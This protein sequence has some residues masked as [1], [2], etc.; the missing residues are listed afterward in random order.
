MPS[1]DPVAASVASVA[2]PVPLAAEAFYGPL[3][4]FVTI[5]D[6]HTEA[7]MAAVLVQAAVAF[8]NAIGRRAYWRAEGDR[9]YANLQAVIVGD[10]SSG[11]KGSGAG[12]ALQVVRLADEE[13]ARS[14]VAS[15][16]ASG[17]GLIH[18]VRDSVITVNKKG[19][20]EV[21]AGVNDK[22]LLTVE[23]EF[24]SVLRQAG[25]DGNILSTTLRQ[26]WDT[27]EL[28]VLTKTTPTRA[29]GA[30]V[31]VIGHITV[32]E[33]RRELKATDKA[34]GFA[35]RVLWVLSR[36][37]KLLPEGGRTPQGIDRVVAG[38][39]RGVLFGRDLHE[40]IRRD[41]EARE[42][43]ASVYP[44][45]TADRGGM[46]GAITGRAEAQVMRLAM[47][48]AMLDQSHKITAD[49]LRAGL[50]VWRYCDD[51][52]RYIFGKASGDTTA[53]AILQAAVRN[54]GRITQTEIQRDVFN[55][56][57]DGGKIAAA[58]ADLQ[59]AGRLVPDKVPTDGRPVTVWHVATEAIKATKAPT[60]GLK[61]LI[62]LSSQPTGG[63]ES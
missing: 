50:E 39:A 43:W 3:G 7:D 19:E 12:R 23:S 11:R 55:N 46:Y 25:R 35:N 60:N 45:L 15:G 61:S 9:H 4:E 21:D 28:R 52:A 17:E 24:A 62:S 27:G 38:F 20:E 37:S 53:D 47:I 49:H 2:W 58:L 29:T 22:R 51:S 32:D 34:N 44:Q 16:L 33:L 56:H 41:D 31:S 1:T 54:G 5:I 6:P 26:A 8:G 42:L 30:H 40:E 48:Y 57:G 13:W 18:A 63:G 59:G 10:T 14:C 36:R